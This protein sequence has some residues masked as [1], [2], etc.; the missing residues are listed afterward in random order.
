MTLSCVPEAVYTWTCGQ[1]AVVCAC[2]FDESKNADKMLLF[3]CVTL[4]RA[5]KADK[6]LLFVCVTL[7]RARK[8][9]R[10]CCLCV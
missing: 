8:L 6:M 10:C 3:V 1:D 7:M 5:T 9:T 2:D 4:M